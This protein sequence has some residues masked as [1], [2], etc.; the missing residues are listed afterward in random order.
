MSISSARKQL[1]QCKENF[2]L[3]INF[4]L[5][6]FR[7]VANGF[8][9]AEG[10]ISCRIRNKNFSPV[11]AINQNLSPKSLEF[12]LT[13]WYVLGRTGTLSITINKRGKF[14][15]RL[16]SES[17]DTILNSYSKYFNHIYGEKYIAFQKLF[18]I[19]RLTSNN[20]LL[21]P[22]SLALATR[23]VYGLSAD[24]VNRKLSLLDQLKLLGLNLTNVK[25]PTYTDNMNSPSILFI[26]GF[27]LGDGT[28]FLK[29]RKS[30]TGSIW[31][32]PTLHLPQLKNRYNAHFFSILEKFFKSLDINTY[33]I[34]NLKDSETLDILN[35]ND[36]NIKEM[37]VLTVESISSMFEKFL[38]SVE[39]YSHYFYWKYEQYELMSIV[40]QLVNAKAHYTLYGFMTIIE[41]IY[42]YTNKRL[43]P[44]FFWIETIQSWFKAEASK[45]KSGQNQIQAVAGRGSFRGCTIAWK[46]KFP[47]ELNLKSRQ[48]GFTNDLESVQALK[49]AIQYRDISIK[50]R[51]E[52]LLA[53]L[54]YI[55]SS[56][57]AQACDA[58][59][60]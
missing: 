49:Q 58:K 41:I 27:I 28:L 54:P 46:C 5:E 11:F 40:A 33:T 20:L 17:W 7:L 19:R 48:F 12:F 38:P 56:E 57:E 26:I 21:D 4:N 18:D 51:V 15:I 37:T 55:K 29:L 36:K 39:P 25:L 6:E 14:V 32:I 47:T 8:F 35:L 10:H 52:S 44:K 53:T 13:L 60:K 31:L 3:P 22:I 45:T 23:I 30:D 34:N 43:Q 24:G 9:Q 42:S 59:P 2:K 1:K 16:S 50:S